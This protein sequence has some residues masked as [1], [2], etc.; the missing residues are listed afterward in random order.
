MPWAAGA[1][2]KKGIKR[3]NFE[4]KLSHD[5]NA[6][7]WFARTGLA[8]RHWRW[9]HESFQE[10]PRESLTME[11]PRGF[12]SVSGDITFHWRFNSIT[13]ISGSFQGHFKTF[14]GCFRR[15]LRS[16]LRLIQEISGAV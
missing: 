3:G 11:V 6:E 15:G 5:F 7:T 4:H 1:Y 10:V 14:Q 16:H 2:I 9:G 12:R 13:V 8:P